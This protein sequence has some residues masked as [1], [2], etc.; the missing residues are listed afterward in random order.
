[1]SSS[2]SQGTKL[3]RYEIRSKI[4][5][6]GMGEVYLAEDMQ[7]HR[8]VALKVLPAEVASNQDRLRRFNQEATAAATLNHPNIAHIYEIGEH[9][10]AYFIVMEFIDGQTLRE[11][12]HDRQTDLNKLLR[13]LQHVAEGLAKAHAAGIVHRDLKPDNIMITR[14]GH[15]KILDF[16][17]AKLIE[18]QGHPGQKPDGEGELGEVATALLAQRST[19][20]TVMGTVGYMSPEQAQ[21]KT[22]QIDHRSDVFSFGCILYE[23]VT[24]H[25][26][27]EGKDAIDSLNKI[28]REPVSPVNNFN[29]AAPPDLQKIVRRCLA[30]DPDERYQSIKDVA[31]ELK[32]VRHEMAETGGLDTTVPPLIS[33]EVVGR[34]S[35]VQ[36]GT[37][38]ADA[39]LNT[40]SAV[41]RP[42]SSA[43]YIVSGIR[44][45][46]FAATMVGGLAALAVVAIG[47]GIY[48]LIGQNK[49]VP[50][51]QATKFT[52]LT[53]TGKATHASISPDGKYVV[54]VM[55]DA[56]RQSLWVRQTVTGSNVQIVPPAEV[57]YWGIT[58]SRDADYVYYVERAK[59]AGLGFL[60]RVPVLGGSPVTLVK[61]VDSP[62]TVSPDS[63]Q[64]AFIRWNPVE[65]TSGVWLANADGTAEHR[66]AMRRDPEDFKGAPA[67]SPDGKVIACA[68]NGLE[69]G[70]AYSTVLGV[71]VAGGEQKPITSKRWGRI[72]RVAWFA[73]DGLI[74]NAA[75][76][77]SILLAQLWYLSYPDGQAKPITHDLNDYADVALTG[78]SNALVTVQSEM[79]SNVWLAP[80][81]DA[82]RA[83]Q[84]TTGK[85][86]DGM[87]VCWSAEGKIVY[88]SAVSGSAD[89]WVMDADG[90]NQR[91]ITSDTHTEYYPSVSADGRYIVFVSDRL[92]TDHIWRINGDGSNPKQ[93]T[94][95]N[96][97]EE[98]PVL[99]PDGRWVVYTSFGNG[100]SL[101]KLSI[102][103]G[104]PEQINKNDVN[105]PAVAPNGEQIAFWSYPDD[106]GTDGLDHPFV[107]IMPFAGG[108]ATKT[109]QVPQTTNF[110]ANLQ[111]SADGRAILYVDTR[112]GVSNIWSQPVEG[113]PAK[114][115]T[116]FQS[117]R[118]FGFASS[119]DSKQLALTRGT[120]S[121]DVVLISNLK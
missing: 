35:L 78:D 38:S 37:Q 103:G 29:P 89:I 97:R 27:F 23:A 100:R 88:D 17:L 76:Q 80:D 51:F 62:I 112:N 115:L 4:G 3:G 44:Q 50:S 110:G 91:Q 114:Q 45:H 104:N 11:C 10:G 47:F 14:E 41:A 111:W 42:T 8:K 83:R 82:R 33:G 13:Y 9:H 5:A 79:Q 30:K 74:L 49:T 96:T 107:R 31:I 39:S 93:L 81:F 56:G 1:M 64:I 24:G 43:E 69:S 72:G 108:S 67:W 25:K 63:R 21:G 71:S 113:G 53:A 66:L 19:P 121:N 60:Y 40:Q 118:I 87:S 52:R 58:F 116:N 77:N 6:G 102:E 75:E 12:M 61:D 119:P 73:N 48:R 32:E 70:V 117:D 65:H 36:S 2:L 90:S 34:Q 84:L 57:E 120:I 106:Y 98:T 28:I 20:G 22:N 95:G 92:G 99:T 101:W 86:R 85:G 105:K 15:A 7:L 54:H 68:M 59:G 46:K 109:F 55:S 94:S 26:A 18:P 16:G